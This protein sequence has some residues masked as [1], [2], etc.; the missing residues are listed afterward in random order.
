MKSLAEHSQVL[1]LLEDLEEFRTG[2]VDGEE[3]LE[4]TVNY[5]I[6]SCQSE[7]KERANGQ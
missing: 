3:S 4:M 7:R 6:Q 2:Q 5:N 1:M